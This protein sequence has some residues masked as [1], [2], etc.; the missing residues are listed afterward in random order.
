MIAGSHKCDLQFRTAGWRSPLG[1]QLRVREVAALTLRVTA[2]RRQPARNSESTCFTPGS[3]HCFSFLHMSHQ[4]CCA[5]EQGRISRCRA[6]QNW[7]HSGITL[8]K[9]VFLFD[10]SANVL[11]KVQTSKTNSEVRGRDWAMSRYSFSIGSRLLLETAHSINPAKTIMSKIGGYRGSTNSP[12]Y[13]LRLPSNSPA[14]HCASI[15][16][17]PLVSVSISFEA[18]LGLQA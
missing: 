14:Q 18:Y 9:F 1:N 8:L 13:S 6:S 11:H 10:V 12:T 4:I 16:L 15:C 17:V 5:T 3:S 7:V 2:Q